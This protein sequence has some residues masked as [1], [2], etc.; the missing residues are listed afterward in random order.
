MTIDIANE[1]YPEWAM[2]S[3]CVDCARDE[4]LR[5][6]IRA[7]PGQDERCGGCLRHALAVVVCALAQRERLSYVLRALVRF[8]YDES[9]YNG[10]IGGDSPEQLLVEDNPILAIDAVNLTLQ[11]E[12]Q[13]FVGDLAASLPH[14]AYDKGIWVYHFND[15]APATAISRSE[16]PDLRSIR[17]R[18]EKENHFVLEPLVRAILDHAGPRIETVLPA[19]TRLHRAR[20]G[21]ADELVTGGWTDPKVFPRPYTGDELGAPPAPIAKTGRLN[22]VGVSFLYLAS[23]VKTAACEVRPHPSHRLSIGVYEST[24]DLRIANL[25]VEIGAFVASD[26]DLDAFHFLHSA[27]HAMTMPV[28]PDAA[29]RYMVTQLIA[30]V[31]RQGG[32]DGVQYASSVGPGHNV[33]V[34][35]PAIFSLIPD[36]E[37]VHRVVRVDYALDIVESRLDAGPEDYVRK[38]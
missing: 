32:Y 23:D 26:T 7:H 2:L 19:G 24:R 29:E 22:R 16:S 11:P 33:C 9:E 25:T 15:G 38:A 20:I 21:I 17:L 12:I 4:T 5:A 30:D 6:F 13:D 27:D 1:E 35:D 10:H 28:P 31:L 36:S 3:L 18:L 14:P 8:H 34:F 37:E